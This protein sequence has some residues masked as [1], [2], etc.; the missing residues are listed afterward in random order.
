M[1]V[2]L[3]HVLSRRPFDHHARMH[4]CMVFKSLGHV[5][6]ARIAPGSAR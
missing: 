4:H 1:S 6:L 5:I 2:Y 3:P